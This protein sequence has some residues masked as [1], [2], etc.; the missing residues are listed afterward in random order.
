MDTEMVS[1]RRG[2]VV[3]PVAAQISIVDSDGHVVLHTHARP[4]WPIVSYNTKYSGI[5]EE[6]LR[7]AP[8]LEKVRAN[9]I[10]LIKGCLLVG[11]AIDNDLRALD[12]LH[13][14]DR[15]VDTQRIPQ[16][17]SML[18]QSTP[19][20]KNVCLALLDTRIQD[21]AHCALQDAKATAKVFGL[22]CAWNWV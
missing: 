3:R 14:V 8:P 15:I 18:S 11:H 19:S 9:V 10:S 5:T 20:L 22:A 12:L 6:H 16:I 21:G 7:D 1:C 4:R 2:G 13:P 17:Q